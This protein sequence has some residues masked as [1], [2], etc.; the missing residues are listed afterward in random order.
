MAEYQVE[1]S[2][3]AAKEYK[4]LPSNIKALID[5]ARASFLK[6]DIWTLSH[7]KEKK[8]LTGSGLVLTEYFI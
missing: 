7:L 2:T 1:F 8:T 3:R 6:A 4:R 5:A